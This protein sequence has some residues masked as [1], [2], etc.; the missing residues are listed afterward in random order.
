MANLRGEGALKGHDLAVAIYDKAKHVDKESGEVKAE[1]PTA[2]L[3]PDSPAAEGQTQSALNSRKD[4]KSR[5]GYNN[6]A[7]YAASQM[8]KIREA[9]GDNVAPLLNKE[10]ESVGQVYGVK[11]DLMPARDKSGFAINTKSLEAS[12]LS[13]QPEGDKT[14]QD[15]I[16]EN[17]TSAKQAKQAAAAEKPAAEQQAQAEA[18]EAEAPAE[19]AQAEAAEPGLG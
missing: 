11:A 6:S 1:F 10:G 13:V 2:Y 14:I 18:P 16:V 3:H 12:D 15:K 5:S 8:S 19:E 4:D 7:P 9:A 17:H